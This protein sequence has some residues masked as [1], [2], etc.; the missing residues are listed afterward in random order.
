MLFP[1][2]KDPDF[3]L[4][5]PAKQTESSHLEPGTPHMDLPVNLD[6][7]GIQSRES[8]KIQNAL[9]ICMLS[10]GEGPAEPDRTNQEV[11]IQV[12]DER[13]TATSRGAW[14]SGPHPVPFT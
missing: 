6:T 2:S 13:M 8:T 3:T 14:L 7:S 4:A 5:V 12:G 9:E 10:S 11:G 1:L